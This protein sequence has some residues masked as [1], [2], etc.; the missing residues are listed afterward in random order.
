M[1]VVSY[2]VKTDVNWSFKMFDFF[3]LSLRFVPF[4]ERGAT[5]LASHFLLF[6]KLCSFFGFPV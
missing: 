6:M 4:D 1:E 2:E 3:T 5:P